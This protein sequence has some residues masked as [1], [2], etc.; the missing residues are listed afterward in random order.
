VLVLYIPRGQALP[1]ASGY[2]AAALVSVIILAAALVASAV[3]ALPV[4]GHRKP[5]PA[6]EVTT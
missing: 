3:F 4:P 2:S 1:S 5:R 6:E